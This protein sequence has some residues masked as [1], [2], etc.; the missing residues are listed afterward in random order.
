MHQVMLFPCYQG[1]RRPWT[2]LAPRPGSSG[3]RASDF[4]RRNTL[5]IICAAIGGLAIARI[6]AF[7]L[8]RKH[9]RCGDGSNPSFSPF[10]VD[11]TQPDSTPTNDLKAAKHPSPSQS[12]SDA[13]LVEPLPNH[14]ELFAQFFASLPDIDEN[15]TAP[16]PYEARRASQP[17]PQY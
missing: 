6:I 14:I 12:S 13:A 9:R 16:P 1:V 17:A 7:L 15:S 2:T 3:P 10:H 4:H 8:Y 5:I 11:P